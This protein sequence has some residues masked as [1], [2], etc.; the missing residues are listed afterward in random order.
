MYILFCFFFFF[1]FKQ[2]TAYEMLRSLVGSE[3]CIR[4]RKR[5][6]GYICNYF[7]FVVFFKTHEGRRRSEEKEE[8]ELYENSI[9]APHEGLDCKKIGPNMYLT[10]AP[11]PHRAECIVLCGCLL[12]LL[13]LFEYCSCCNVCDIM[14]QFLSVFRI[15]N[16]ENNKTF[17]NFQSLLTPT[18]HH[19]Q[20]HAPPCTHSTHI[21]LHEHPL[22]LYLIISP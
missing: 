2:K 22:A 15:Q 5:M 21:L 8:K 16:G 13:L 4:D 17:G 9:P 18:V 12:L 14:L 7:C 6:G 10:H 3:M 11:V 1:F 19:T 20:Q